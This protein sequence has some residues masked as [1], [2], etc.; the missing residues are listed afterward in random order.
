MYVYILCEDRE[1][2]DIIIID[3]IR[4]RMFKMESHVCLELT[5]MKKLHRSSPRDR[6][7]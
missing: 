5:K 7:R 4:S 3:M 1:I 6:M 2:L